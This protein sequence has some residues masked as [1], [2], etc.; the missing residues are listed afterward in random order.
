MAEE[1]KEMDRSVQIQKQRIRRDG[2]LIFIASS[3]RV[4]IDLRILASS[5]ISQSVTE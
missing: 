5:K 1:K 4:L 3:M 2:R